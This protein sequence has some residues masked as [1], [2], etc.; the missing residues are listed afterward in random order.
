MEL[1]R[2]R[3]FGICSS[4]LAIIVARFN[5]HITSGL[6]SGAQEAIKRHNV[7]SHDVF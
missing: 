7:A 2:C 4:A 6:L 5:E 3:L 1:H